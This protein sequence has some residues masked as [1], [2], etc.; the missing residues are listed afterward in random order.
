L[1]A[2]PLRTVTVAKEVVRLLG[3]LATEPPIAIA[4][5][6]HSSCTVMSGGIVARTLLYASMSRRGRSSRG[7]RSPTKQPWRAGP[8]PHFQRTG[9]PQRLQQ[10]LAA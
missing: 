9:I 5:P 6:E 10:A 8:W 7:P 1:R 2:M 4:G 3:D